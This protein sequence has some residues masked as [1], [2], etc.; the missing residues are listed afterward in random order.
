MKLIL[1]AFLLLQ[2]TVLSDWKDSTLE[3]AKT[4][5]KHIGLQR[6][7]FDDHLWAFNEIY[8]SNCGLQEEL[9]TL[10]EE[11]AIETIFKKSDCLSMGNSKNSVILEAAQKTGSA[12]LLAYYFT[13]ES[14]E[15]EQKWAEFQRQWKSQV[16]QKKAHLIEKLIKREWIEFETTSDP[17]LILGILTSPSRDQ[18]ISKA[19]LP[20]IIQYLEGQLKSY[21]RNALEYSITLSNII[22]AANIIYDDTTILKHSDGFLSSF[23]FPNSLIKIKRINVI[24]FS[25]YIYGNYDRSL[26]IQRKF[27]L[28]LLKFLNETEELDK[29]LS[30]H[31]AYL[32]TLGKYQESKNIYELLVDEQKSLFPA[33][34]LFNNLSINYLKLG[35]KNKYL[36]FQFRALEYAQSQ[37]NSKH[38]LNIYRNLFIYYSSIKDINSAL[39]YIEK[40]KEVAQKNADLVEL[41][42]IE[43][44]LGT[45]YW[46]TYKDHHKSLY[47]FNLAE[48]SLSEEENYETYRDLL[49]GKSEIFLKTDS[50]IAAHATLNKLKNLTLDKSDTPAY[51]HT[52]VLMINYYLKMNQF[53]L[54]AKNLKEVTL[55]SLDYLDF[56]VLTKYHTTKSAY[57]SKTGNTRD[58]IEILAPVVDQIFDRTKNSTDT[59]SGFWTVEDEYLDAF[60]LM[61][62]L[63]I[64]IENPEKA[65]ILLDQIKT[66]NDAYLYNSPLVKAAKLTENELTSEKRL[67]EQIQELRKKYLN[68]G[69]E[70]RFK[71]KMEI[72]LLSAEREEILNRAN[73]SKENTLTPIWSIQR[74]IQEDEL[75]MHFT[76]LGTQL[77][78]TKLSSN[79]IQIETYTLDKNEIKKLTEIADNLAAG[80]TNLNDLYHIYKV[81]NLN[82]LPS[83]I[84]HLTIIP[85][86]YLY[87]I[88]LEILPTTKPASTIS[89]GSA[90]Y[91]VEDYHFRYFTSL[92][93]YEKNRRSVEN[94]NENDFSVF[95]ISDFEKFESVNL[96]DLPYATTEADNIYNLLQSFDNKHIYT[97]QNATKQKFLESTGNSKIV[98][99]ATHSEIS[100]QN[101]LFSTIYLKGTAG[102]STSESTQALYAYELFEATLNSDFIMLNSCSSGSGNYMQGTGIMG[103]SRALRYA[104]AKSLALNLWSVNDK[105]ASDFASS[106]YSYINDGLS[107]SEA[108]RKA[109]LDQLGSANANPHFWGAYMM[110]GNPAPLT[111]NENP[112]F[113]YTAL[114]S[115]LIAAGFSARK[116]I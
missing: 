46:S 49:L 25:N 77:Y 116:L 86:N 75:L 9:L 15:L 60:E 111:D 65:L 74:V 38:L 55:H 13:Q 76:E 79:D 105:V 11:P 40:A 54:A 52:V 68:A 21:N 94:E 98:H 4:Y 92:Q 64:D 3:Q 114:I 59:Q 45:F 41:A 82:D 51:L 5:S 50:L 106:F 87:R 66:L 1:V 32:F 22:A 95:A 31:G 70:E 84:N 81:L 69:D 100:E 28:P 7:G 20:E 67:N 80:K 47:H 36:T 8:F 112:Y 91:L 35:Q 48:E 72:D 6:S 29:V 34:T 10:L 99:V 71:F 102:N 85:D 93:E 96:P 43:S 113:I 30:R 44:F 73:L 62:Q 115:I 2:Q 17:L 16:P 97:E 88:P 27:S 89:Y 107:K 90:H 58:A 61:V 33:S 39:N 12:D 42:R 109:K 63:Y 18:F 14:D 103:I 56:E 78:L 19:D 53:D 83:H 57:L 101:P 37:N 23:L 108:I 104:G 24:D 26:E 110:I